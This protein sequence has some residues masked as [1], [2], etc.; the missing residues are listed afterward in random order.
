MTINP[1][2]KKSPMGVSQMHNFDKHEIKIEKTDSRKE[3]PNDSY[4][5]ASLLFFFT[6]LAGALPLHFFLVANDYWMYKLRDPEYETYNL[7]DKT[8]YQKMFTSVSLAV[9]GFPCMISAYLSA[10]FALKIDVRKRFLFTLAIISFLFVIFTSLVK[11]NTDGWQTVFFI[12]SVTVITVIALFHPLYNITMM[13]LLSTFPSKYI[14]LNMYGSAMAGIFSS[15]LQ[16]I[17]LSISNSPKDVAMI[18]FSLG[19]GIILFTLFL[20]YVMKYSPVV[21]Y[22]WKGDHEE[23]VVP[24]HTLRDFKNVAFIIW[25]L[26]IIL[27]LT[28]G[29]SGLG[30]PNITSLVVSDGYNDHR[31]NLWYSKYFVPT[32]TFL[33][34]DIF[35]LLGRFFGQAYITRKNS[36]WFIILTAVRCF[37]IGSLFFFCNARPRNYFPVLFPYD[38]EYMIILYL[39]SFSA[40]FIMTTVILSSPRMAGDQAEVA[41]VSIQVVASTTTTLTSF[42]DPFYVKML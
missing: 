6:G 31:D 9:Q 21:E 3:P 7:S 14:K 1:N 23:H 33:G 12:T 8:Y 4:F 11:I 5:I 34:T 40:S 37:G 29:T 32:V 41:F 15:C 13:A 10:K 42:L 22:Y 19:T 28:N 24:S 35:S 38:F 2:I 17:S 36:H 26:L 18:Y 27:V 16:I 25:P 20:T 30:H 39:Y